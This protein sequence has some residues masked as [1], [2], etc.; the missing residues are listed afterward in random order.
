[1]SARGYVR[2]PFLLYPIAQIAVGTEF[3]ENSMDFPMI[4]IHSVIACFLV[5]MSIHLEDMWGSCVFE[6]VQ[7]LLFCKQACTSSTAGYLYTGLLDD[8]LSHGLGRFIFPFIFPEP[9]Y[10][11]TASAQDFFRGPAFADPMLPLFF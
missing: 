1:M 5:Q 2:L 8:N 9:N 10:T 6:N 11:L 7:K 4:V 3:Q